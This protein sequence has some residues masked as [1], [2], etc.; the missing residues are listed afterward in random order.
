MKTILLTGASGQVGWELRRTLAPLGRV[1][2]PSSA[3]LDLADADAIC[4]IVR[5]V[6][7]HL[8]V[9][10]AAYTAVDKAESESGSA[11]AV[12]G[13]A[14]GILAEEAK[15][16][17][18]KLVHYSTDYVFDGTKPGP[19]RENDSPGPVSSYGRS[20]LA[21]EEAIRA[22][23]LPHLIFRTGWVY[24]AR[25][26]NF[27]LTMLRLAKERDALRVV[28]DQFGA[29]TWSRMIAEA[30]ALAIVRWQ[31][32]AD[33]SG[34]FHLTNAGQTSWHGFAQAILREYQ[35]RQAERSWPPLKA[36]PQAIAAI[37]AEQYPTPAQRPANSVLDNTKLRETFG[38]ELPD[39]QDALVLV[40]EEAATL[41]V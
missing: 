25:G 28:A 10:P 27:M 14:P 32:A 38:L 35:A 1:I 18:A 9:N 6:R 16:M 19:Y 34:V 17:H 33:L 11:M 26:K 12:N 13:V 29:P 31:S 40:M 4:R 20:K 24:G 30:T 5:E 8:I 41:A 36:S 2:A 37:T 23:G 39:W 21:G 22:A 15:R 7:P 3:E